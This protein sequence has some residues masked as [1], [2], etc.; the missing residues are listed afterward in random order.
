M[1]PDLLLP[2]LVRHVFQPRARFGVE[3]RPEVGALVA[4]RVYVWP[5]SH[6]GLRAAGMAQSVPPPA[7]HLAVASSAST[8]TPCMTLAWHLIQETLRRK[9]LEWLILSFSFAQFSEL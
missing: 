5:S 9:L 3:H 6:Y 4:H 1:G 7:W 8:G 2:A